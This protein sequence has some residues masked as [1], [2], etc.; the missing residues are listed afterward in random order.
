MINAHSLEA[1]KRGTF[2]KHFCRPLYDSYCFSKLPGT[3]QH[4][5]GVETE[6]EKMPAEAFGGAQEKFDL[7]ILLFVD[8]FGWRFFEKYAPKYPFLQRFIDQ[9]VVSKITAQFPST[10]AA[11]VTCINTGIPVGQSGIY[12]WFYY[13]PEVG[14]VIAPLLFSFAGDGKTDTLKKAGIS[15]AS[16]YPQRTLYEDLHEKGVTSYVFQGANIAHSTYSEVMFRGAKS[17]PYTTLPQGLQTLTELANAP[18]TTPLYAY[19]YFADIDSMG[20]RHGIDTPEFEKSVHHIFTALEEHFW[21]K[22]SAPEGKKIATLLVADHGMVSVDPKTTLYLNKEIPTLLN[23]FKKDSRKEP[24]APAGSCRDFFLHIEEKELHETAEL[25]RKFFNGKAE[26][27]L[28]EQLIEQGLFGPNPSPRFLQRAGNLVILPYAGE[29][30]WWYEK[31]RF[32]QHFFGAHG[33]L[34]PQEM[35]IPLLFQTVGS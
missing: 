21:K 32:E 35:E 14:R 6:L 1:V 16:I 26:I 27:Y 13:E 11:H 2:S 30:I 19:I 28:T 4:L 29:A 12:E 22:M 23:H 18:K 17:L 15:P 33:G 34:T 10:T 7:V 24:I 3:I 31:G 9:G 20:H 25:L 5:L 8:G